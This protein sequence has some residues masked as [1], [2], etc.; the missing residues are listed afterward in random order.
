MRKKGNKYRN[1]CENL[2]ERND[3]EYL[4]VWKHNI[5]TRFKEIGCDI[6]WTSHRAYWRAVLN[7][8]IHVQIP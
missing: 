4:A 6:A 2:K 5:K 1:W 7:T 3:F 8:A